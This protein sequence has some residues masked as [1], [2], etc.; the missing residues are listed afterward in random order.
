MDSPYSG[1]P[2]VES[3][4]VAAIMVFSSSRT[5][6]CDECTA[7]SDGVVTCPATMRGPADTAAH[8]Y[9]DTGGASS[10]QCAS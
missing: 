3:Q 6:T 2:L 1:Q 8:V 4:D 7:S 10:V 9:T 5:F